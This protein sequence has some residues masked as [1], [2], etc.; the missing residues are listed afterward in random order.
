MVMIEATTM[1]DDPMIEDIEMN[2]AIAKIGI[3]RTEAIAIE[4]V[5]MMS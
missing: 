3:V 1:K 5:A 2:V 4:I